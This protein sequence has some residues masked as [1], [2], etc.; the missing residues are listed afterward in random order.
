MPMQRDKY[1][2]DWEQISRRIRF[3][4]ANNHCEWCGVQNG[5]TGARDR[6]GVWHDQHDIN[7]MKSSVGEMLFGEYPKMIRIV[8]TVAHID[9]DTTHNDDSNLAALCQRCHLNHDRDHHLANRKLTYATRRAARVAAT[10]QL[11]LFQST[12]E[13]S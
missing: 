11:D 10:G 1:P 7:N 4:R 5:A 8:L 9:H 3:E 13:Q 6:F 12:E 2:P